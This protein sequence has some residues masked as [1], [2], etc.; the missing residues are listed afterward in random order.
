[1]R[2]NSIIVLDYLKGSLDHYISS[3][4]I[5][6]ELSKEEAL[7][8]II[9]PAIAH[10]LKTHGTGILLEKD[11]EIISTIVETLEV[12]ETVKQIMNDFIIQIQ[13]IMK[14]NQ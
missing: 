13:N 5:E 12:D 4:M 7:K 11:L 8:T 9:A 1:M 14:G 2:E 10:L 6:K 3:I